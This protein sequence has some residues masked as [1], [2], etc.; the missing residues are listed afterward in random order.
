MFTR[1]LP[2]PQTHIHVDTQKRALCNIPGSLVRASRFEPSSLGVICVCRSAPVTPRRLTGRNRLWSW[3]ALLGG[4]NGFALRLL[5]TSSPQDD[6][7]KYEDYC[8]QRNRRKLGYRVR[9]TDCDLMHAM[10]GTRVKSE[11]Y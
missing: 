8:E 10:H 7:G 5:R 2:R 6:H 3:A 9:T 1:G 4:C 11:T